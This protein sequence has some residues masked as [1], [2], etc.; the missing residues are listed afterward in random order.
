[1]DVLV[2]CGDPQLAECLIR[3]LQG[4]KDARVVH[5]ENCTDDASFVLPGGSPDLVVVDVRDKGSSG[6]AIVYN[7]RRALPSSGIIAVGAGGSRGL[8]RSLAECGSD[9]FVSAA[10]ISEDLLRAA[11][12]ITR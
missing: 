10:R 2:L 1:M 6:L 4:M 7:L 8:K 5:R 3:P 9:A 11:L 12:E